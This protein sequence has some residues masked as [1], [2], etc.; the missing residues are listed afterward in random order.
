MDTRT[1]WEQE[2]DEGPAPGQVIEPSDDPG[3]ATAADGAGEGSTALDD[4]PGEDE[5]RTRRAIGW[6]RPLTVLA[7]LLMTLGW[8][9]NH[10][11]GGRG[12]GT[13]SG[14]RG[15][16]RDPV[17]PEREHRRG[18]GHGRPLGPVGRERGHRWRR[19][20]REGGRGRQRPA[21]RAAS[22]RRR[23]S[24]VE[25]PSPAAARTVRRRQRRRRRAAASRLPA[26]GVKA[27]V[28]VR[29]APRVSTPTSTSGSRPRRAA[30]S[31]RSR[32]VLRDDQ[33]PEPEARRRG[34]R[35]PSPTATRRPG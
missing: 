28:D 14:R 2:L 15:G 16:R 30:P 8:W 33:Q 35:S 13:G 25:R 26:A 6:L 9:L 1:L 4:H 11:S 31:R 3:L 24:P 21:R 29:S 22:A 20:G 17:R 12:A 32:D 18:S 7:L 27:D 19:L 10:D 23:P 5:H 34:A